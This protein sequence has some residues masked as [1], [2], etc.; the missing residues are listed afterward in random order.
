M[1]V[2]SAAIKTKREAPRKMSRVGDRSNRN[3]NARSKR[4]A[5]RNASDATLVADVFF[6]KM[7]TSII[8]DITNVSMYSML[9]LGISY[10]DIKLEILPLTKS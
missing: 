5:F 3:W 2:S 9:I 7:H 4:V 1:N 8:N 10:L 6:G